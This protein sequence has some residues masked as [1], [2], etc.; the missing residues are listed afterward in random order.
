MISGIFHQGSGL[1]NQLHRY[2]AT[3]VLALDKKCDFSIVAPELF[4]G[5]SFMNLDMGVQPSYGYTIKGPSGKVLPIGFRNPSTPYEG[6]WEEKMNYYNPEFNFIEDDTIIDGEFQSEQYFGHR[7]DEINEWLKVE[8]IGD[9][10]KKPA[11]DLCMVGFRGG[12][13][14]LY[15]ELFLTVD[16]WGEAI[17]KMWELNPKMKFEIHTDDKPLAEIF[18]KGLID[19]D[20]NAVIHDIGINW[21]SMRYAQYAIIANSSFYILPRLLASRFVRQPVTIAPRYWARRNTKEWSMPQNFY[22]SFLYV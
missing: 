4:K 8:P 18:F 17:N 13:F 16:Y 7:L 22:K 2:V 12:E 3:K 20:K 14:A 6:V 5:K 1:G 15:P 10:L 21:R 9:P 19:Y 11:E